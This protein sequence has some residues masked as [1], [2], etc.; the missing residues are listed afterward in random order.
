MIKPWDRYGDSYFVVMYG[1]NIDITT[2]GHTPS[3]RFYLL[4]SFGPNTS[5]NSAA[6]SHYFTFQFHAR[7]GMSIF[8]IFQ[9]IPDAPCMEYLP[10]CGIN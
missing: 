1:M 7:W 3:Y 5:Y 9:C 10:T 6:N 8:V 4:V 2:V